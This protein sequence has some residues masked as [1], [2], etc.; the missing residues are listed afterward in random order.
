MTISKATKPH[1]YS[2]VMKGRDISGEA[3]YSQSGDLIYL[4]GAAHQHYGLTRP[5]VD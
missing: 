3:V 2:V 5:E 1:S 4:K